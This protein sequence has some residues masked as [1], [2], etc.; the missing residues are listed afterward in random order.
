MMTQREMKV[1]LERL[2]YRLERNYRCP[3]RQ[4]VM[5]FATLPLVSGGTCVF[6][7]AADVARYIEQVEQM[8]EWLAEV[9]V[10]GSV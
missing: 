6:E 9:K 5:P 2:G 4:K 3:I 7:R 1:R 8:R 10:A